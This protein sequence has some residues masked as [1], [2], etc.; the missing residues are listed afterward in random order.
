MVSNLKPKLFRRNFDRDSDRNYRNFISIPISISIVGIEIEK[1]IIF[2]V[3]NVVTTVHYTINSP[4]TFRSIFDENISG[5]VEISALIA[6]LFFIPK[7]EFQ[8]RNRNQN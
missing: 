1:A 2:C 5:K 6:N 8:H 7:S 4:L 3:L